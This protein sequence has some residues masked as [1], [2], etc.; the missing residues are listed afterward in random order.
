MGT[1]GLRT[2]LIWHDEVMSDLVHEKPA[3]VT[4]GSS[5]E[6]TFTTPAISGASEYAIV[7]PGRRGYLLTLSDQM[8]GTICLGGV[9]Q[10]VAAFVRAGEEPTG[11][12]ATPIG[13]NDWGVI[14]L[15]ATGDHKLF[16][17]FVPLEEADWNL[18]H[19]MILA[20]V[21]GFGLSVAA[22]TG[23]WAWKGV[24]IGEA[25]F[26]ASSLSSLAIGL[27]AVVRWVL[28]QDNESRASLAFS[29][30]LHAAL[31]FATFQLYER[32]SPFEW[33]KQDA[34]SG[35][36]L[37]KLD[38]LKPPKPE[39]VAKPTVGAATPA[40]V[41][42]MPPRRAWTR[43]KGKKVPTPTLP[44]KQIAAAVTPKQETGTPNPT[45]GLNP[46]PTEPVGVLKQG[47][48]IQKVLDRDIRT[49][50]GRIGEIGGGNR[51]G[52]PD[53]EPGGGLG[54]TKGGGDGKGP[55][56]KQVGSGPIQTGPLRTAMCMGAGCGNGPGPQ[57][58]PPPVPP[59]NNPPTL[60]QAEI[61]RVI[62]ARAN[63]YRT[64]Y[65]K[66]LNREPTL[67]GDIAIHFEILPD[68]TVRGQKRTGGSMT[69]AAVI[70]CVKNALGLLHFPQKGGALVN[71][72]FVFSPGQ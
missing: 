27:A 19:P 53:G 33:P 32:A 11:F 40:S 41:D 56:G 14:S 50:I 36:Y 37:V 69:N 20:A 60:T 54:V 47:E 1:T 16:F 23:L 26:R 43:P 29:V 10:D 61:D 67:A 34:V 22:L 8:H 70:Q 18:G 4:I 65:Q 45:P 48:L 55:V 72:P 59:P 62:R 2:S 6:A 39:P 12:R 42:P 24:P 17:Q 46:N 71:Y 57:V 13:G 58:M 9:E 68:G 3:K 30:M 5:V 66:E 51:T 49:A 35:G 7:T 44:N 64:C 28:K 38:E 25:V 63:M 15:D 21:G 31:L 52:A